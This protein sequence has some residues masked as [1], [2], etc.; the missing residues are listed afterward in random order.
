MATSKI[1]CV[2]CRD[3]YLREEMYREV[4][5]KVCSNTCLQDYLAAL[6]LKR[7]QKTA[8]RQAGSERRYVKKRQRQAESLPITVRRRIKRRDDEHC[9]WCGTS[10]N[11]QVHHIEYRSQG[12][13]DEDHN[14]I[15]LCTEHH[16]A[17]HSNKRVYQPLCRA[18]IWLLYVDEMK[19]TIPY[20]ERQFVGASDPTKVGTFVS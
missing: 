3:Y 12:G 2:F 20:A 19:V 15:T 16:M 9:R 4:S 11:L 10:S 8:D 13:T 17:I 7:A 14:L 5:P 18:Y 1:R 6:R